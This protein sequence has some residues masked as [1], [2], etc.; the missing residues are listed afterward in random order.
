MMNKPQ[1]SA[2]CAAFDLPFVVVERPRPGTQKFA[3][4]RYVFDARGQSAQI[5]A[6]R[7]SSAKAPPIQNGAAAANQM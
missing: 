5:Q 1:R 6:A 4:R 2:R 3:D 7:R